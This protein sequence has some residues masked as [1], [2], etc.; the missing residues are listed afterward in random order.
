MLDENNSP[1][2]IL[3]ASLD[4]TIK[5]GIYVGNQIGGVVGTVTPALL[6]IKWR[7]CTNF[8][9]S[10]PTNCNPFTC[11]MTVLAVG[12]VSTVGYFVGGFVGSLFGEIISSFFAI[13]AFP[14]QAIYMESSI[15][16]S[17]NTHNLRE[18]PLSDLLVGLDNSTIEDILME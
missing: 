1:A 6:Y 4:E 16:R 10:E 12:A 11:F 5:T 17:D 15:I 18:Q 13:I 7:Y 14:I 9:S 8:E 2:H 3:V